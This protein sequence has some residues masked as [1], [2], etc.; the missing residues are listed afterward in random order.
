MSNGGAHVSSDA[1]PEAA[2]QDAAAATNVLE[3]LRALLFQ[4]LLGGSSQGG[5]R[6]EQPKQHPESFSP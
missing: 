5:S 4:G 1:A 2:Q 6:A 3:R